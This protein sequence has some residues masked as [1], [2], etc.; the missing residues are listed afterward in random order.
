MASVIRSLSDSR[1]A[2]GVINDKLQDDAQV[3]KGESDE[4]GFHNLGRLTRFS[5]RDLPELNP[6]DDRCDCDR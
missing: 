1:L 6:G 3:G 4:M 5:Q 2:P